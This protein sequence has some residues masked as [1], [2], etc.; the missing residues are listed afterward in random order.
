ML[1]H[2]IHLGKLFLVC[3]RVRTEL[4]GLL[5]WSL[6]VGSHLIRQTLINIHPLGSLLCGH[7]EDWW[8]LARVIDDDVIDVIVI[9]NVRDVTSR[10]LGLDALMLL[11]LL[12]VSRRWTSTAHAEPLAIRNSLTFKPALVLTLLSHRVLSELLL[13][14]KWSLLIVVPIAVDKVIVLLM[15]L[16]I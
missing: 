5:S 14:S 13:A 4:L 16:L 11:L 9:N 12:R 1:I 8:G 2:V 15:I 10:A 7:V 6:L 3:Q